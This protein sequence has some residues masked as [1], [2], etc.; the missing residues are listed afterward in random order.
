LELLALDYRPPDVPIQID[1]HV[2]G[3]QGSFNPGPG[4]SGLD[5]PQQFA[6]TGGKAGDLSAGFLDNA[7]LCRGN[8]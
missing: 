6:V 7:S 1:Q 4:D 2:V 8:R 3:R 5:L